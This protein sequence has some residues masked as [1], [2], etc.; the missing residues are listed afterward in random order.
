MRDPLGRYR[1]AAQELTHVTRSAADKLLGGLLRR[2]G[3]ATGNAQEFVEEI[4]ERSQENREAVTAMVRAETRRVVNAMGLAT[5]ADVERLERELAQLRRELRQQSAEATTASSARATSSTAA[6]ATGREKERGTRQT[7]KKTASRRT[8]KKAAGSGLGT[9]GLGE[10]EE[11]A[12]TV[13]PA[14]SPD[15]QP[16]EAPAHEGIAPRTE[17][18]ASR[19]PGQ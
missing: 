4:R 12:S 8:A 3:S 18:R 7:A 10:K 14:S 2:G 13:R 19:D 11:A 9:P 6:T 15:P 17:E 5:A 1:E 16:S